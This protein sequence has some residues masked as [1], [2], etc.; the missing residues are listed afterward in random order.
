MAIVNNNPRSTLLKFLLVL[1]MTIS[2]F[3]ESAT[4]KYN[5]TDPTK[6]SFYEN[7][8]SDLAWTK[9]QE[10]YRKSFAPG[11]LN[12][13]ENLFV[14][15]GWFFAVIIIGSI[16]SSKPKLF[17][18]LLIL[19]FIVFTGIFIVLEPIMVIFAAFL[20][21]ILF[22]VVMDMN[23][24]VESKTHPKKKK[25]S[26][27]ELKALRAKLNK[28]SVD[29][30]TLKCRQNKQITFYDG[31]DLNPV[32][33]PILIELLIGFAEGVSIDQF[34]ISQKLETEKKISKLKKD[35]LLITGKYFEAS[36]DE[37]QTKT[38]ISSAIYDTFSDK[39]KEGIYIN[40]IFE[41]FKREENSII[42]QDYSNAKT[43]IESIEESNKRWRK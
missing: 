1:V 19:S 11:E 23:D 24:N 2:I 29:E 42:G 41:D 36:F 13:L 25:Y 28:L 15:I 32:T 43:I 39:N 22:G 30:L 38:E 16:L 26:N 9:S 21:L 18:W 17:K 10:K 5:T 31:T 14:L 7:Y 4:A 6:A 12:W 34:D 27:K 40:L 37:K 20:S 33:K 3:S 8:E 35:T